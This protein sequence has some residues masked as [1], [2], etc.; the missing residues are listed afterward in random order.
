MFTD[1]SPLITPTDHPEL[2]T[3]LLGKL[4]RRTRLAG[5]LGEL[6]PLAVRIGLVQ[7]SLRPRLR[8]PRLL[9]FAGD[10]G[11][12]VDVS[13]PLAHSTTAVVNDILHSRVPLPVFAHHQG[14]TVEVVDSGLAEP[15]PRCPGLLARKIAHGTRNCRVAQAMTLEQVHAAI[16]AGMEIVESMPGNVL[17][18]AGIGVGSHEASALLISRLIDVP[19]H[20]I[21]RSGPAMEATELDHLV[22]VLQA[23]QSRH[24]GIDDPV[25]ALAAFG[26]FETAM[27]VGAMLKAAERRSLLLVDGLSAC[28]ALIVAAQIAGPVADYCIFCRSTEHAG[29]DA[30][31]DSLES[32]ALLALG[33]NSID[34]TGIAL[35]WPLVSA[36]AALLSDVADT[37][38]PLPPQQLRTEDPVAEAPVREFLRT[39]PSTPDF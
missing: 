22:S 36:A 13:S 6:E 9:V 30:V 28:A 4:D 12:A 23:A 2:E 7:A 19:L 34:G 1:D 20:A 39:L 35:S 25:E 33:M 3:A 38:E 21:L 15:V 17:G 18:C 37:V 27:M 5:H 8:Q 10:H 31:L 14:L 24:T 16:R 29:L 32:T 11:L 26:G